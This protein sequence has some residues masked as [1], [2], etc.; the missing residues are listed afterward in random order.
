MKQNNH[1]L[2]TLNTFHQ[3]ASRLT[4]KLLNCIN[5]KSIHGYLAIM[6]LGAGIFA[7]SCNKEYLDIDN[8]PDLELSPVWALPLIN[9]TISL[10]DLLNEVDQ[11]FV[12]PSPVDNLMYL[13][14]RG[15][16][17]SQTAAQTFVF[18]D[19]N[20]S[21]SQSGIT[22]PAGHFNTNDSIVFSY[23]QIISLDSPNGERIDSIFFDQGA[24]RINPIST[25]NY[26]TRM[27]LEIPTMTKNG[28]SF[29]MS[30]VNMSAEA[31]KDLNDYILKLNHSGGNNRY[32]I[33]YRF[34][35]QKSNDNNNSPYTAGFN[36]QMQNIGFS[37]LY[38]YLGQPEFEILA[39][40]IAISIYKNNTDGMFQLSDPKVR[41]IA[42]NSFGIPIDIHFS[43]FVADEGNNP[44]YIR[45]VSGYP[46]PWAIGFPSLA[47]AG[48]TVE[49]SF[50]MDK[51]NSNVNQVLEIAPK[52]MIYDIWGKG[53]P[54]GTQVTNYVSKDSRFSV[55]V[56]VEMPIYGSTSGFVIQDTIDFNLQNTVEQLE[57]A[58]FNINISN[59]FPVNAL[60]QL[61]FVDSLNVKV[62]SLFATT[63]QMNIIP[64]ALTGPEPEV[65]VLAPA[66]KNTLIMIENQRVENLI[67]KANKIIIRSTLQTSHNGEKM[68]K[69]YSD[70]AMGI[71]LGIKVKAKQKI[72]LKPEP[73]DQ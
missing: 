56:E 12:F 44:P 3:N 26:P 10:E 47:Q 13:I 24:V 51:D 5:L 32:Q 22:I 39:D 60:V 46:N 48:T 57:W 55:D 25:F 17:F 58:E 40:S 30:T 43:K 63:D 50:V 33:N 42:M 6:V 20:F 15:N 62:D 8:Y 34:S 49:T 16:V 71:R 68:V 59:G 36:M 70:Y 38:G 37:K 28:E 19:Q 66:V 64:G 31:T 52:R 73:E 11:N 53:N 1:R 27:Y 35:V 61:Y 67:G 23:S 2:R 21:A 72:S 7:Y 54:Q 18:P 9:S 45:M 14:Y 41:M 29:K 69:F 65:R 4:R